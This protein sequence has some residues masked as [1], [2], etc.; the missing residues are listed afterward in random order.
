[1][2]DLMYLLIFFIDK[3]PS[4]L[5]NVCFRYGFD[6]LRVISEIFFFTPL[7]ILGANR[8]N[9]RLFIYVYISS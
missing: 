4:G 8:K 9:R 1:M 5:P 2:H 7:W 3:W 6:S